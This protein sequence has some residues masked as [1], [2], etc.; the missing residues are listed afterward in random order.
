MVF[1]EEVSNHEAPCAS[2]PTSDPSRNGAVSSKWSAAFE[3]VIHRILAE[4]EGQDVKVRDGMGSAMR[5]LFE[6]PYH[7]ELGTLCGD[8]PLEVEEAQRVFFFPRLS[9]MRRYVEAFCLDTP[10]ETARRAR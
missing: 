2:T 7:V 9:D 1:V 5:K 8:G 4:Y 6:N 3:A 10:E